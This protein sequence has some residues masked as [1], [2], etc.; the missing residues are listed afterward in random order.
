MALKELKIIRVEGSPLFKIKYKNGGEMP[1]CLTGMYTSEGRAQLA[2]KEYLRTR[3]NKK[4]VST[5]DK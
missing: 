3:R 5:S 4:D 2:I 1:K